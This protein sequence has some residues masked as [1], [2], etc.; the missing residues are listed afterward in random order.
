MAGKQSSEQ[1]LKDL[2]FDDKF[3]GRDI[4][5]EQAIEVNKQKANKDFKQK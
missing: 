1:D 3:S 2:E 4:A 5:K